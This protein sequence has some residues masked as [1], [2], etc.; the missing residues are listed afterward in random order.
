MAG[1][2]IDKAHVKL[3]FW[4]AVGFFAFSLMLALA[5]DAWRKGKKLATPPP[6]APSQAPASAYG[7]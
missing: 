7:G 6:P 4:L 5:K 1:P 3:G 2:K